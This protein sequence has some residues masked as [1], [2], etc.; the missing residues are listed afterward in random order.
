MTRTMVDWNDFAELPGMDT[1]RKRPGII[2][3][4]LVT[5][6]RWLNK[7]PER[8][9][10]ALLPAY[11]APG[12]MNGLG[13]YRSIEK[14]NS[15][16]PVDA[17]D[18]VY[19]IVADKKSMCPICGKCDDQEPGWGG[20]LKHK[21]TFCTPFNRLVL[22]KSIFAKNVVCRLQGAHYHCECFNSECK[23]KWIVPKT[24]VKWTDIS[25]KIDKVD[26]T[27]KHMQVELR[28]RME[29]LGT[30]DSGAR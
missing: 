11:Q 24:D 23:T 14:I 16:V 10:V 4:I 1:N 30:S 8:K 28:R 13:P 6:L 17:A 20:Y 5:L 2:S 27:V 19:A 18:G 22:K 9:E 15:E 21:S 7:R 25:T 3:R 26:K 29:D 12:A